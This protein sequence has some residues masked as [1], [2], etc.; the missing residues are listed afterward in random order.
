M[1]TKVPQMTI[2]ILEQ[3]T[4]DTQGRRGEG[5]IQSFGE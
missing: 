2:H 3:Q 1:Q 4:D 5:M